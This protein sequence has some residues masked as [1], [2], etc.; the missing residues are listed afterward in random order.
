MLRLSSTRIKGTVRKGSVNLYSFFTNG[1]VTKRAINVLLI[2]SERVVEPSKD[3]AGTDGVQPES[4]TKIQIQED[5]T[6]STHEE[7]SP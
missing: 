1:K 7:S 3:T 2:Q 6:Q 4:T 5:L